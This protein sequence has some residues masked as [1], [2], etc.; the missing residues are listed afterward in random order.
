MT[1]KTMTLKPTRIV[2]HLLL[3]L[4]LLGLTLVWLGQVHAAALPAY[5]C[6]Y[7]SGTN[8]R[9]CE[10]WAKASVGGQELEMPDGTLI[11]FWGYASADLGAPELPGPAI[12]A[13]QGETV[14]VIL[15]NNLAAEPTALHF[16][17]QGLIP[18]QTGAAANGGTTT[19][20]FSASQ[21]GTFLYEAGL[22]PNSQHQ[23]AMGMFGALIVRPTVA[24]SQAYADASTVFQDEALLV[25][26]E[27]DP[28]LNANPTAFDMRKYAPKYWLINGK[29][30][31]QTA[32]IPSAATNS[33][34]L[35]YINA[36]LQ[37][38]TMN[39]L[40]LDQVLLAVDG[41]PLP[42][43]RKVV[44]NTV[45]PGQTVDTLVA[46]PG[47]VPA[48]GAKY[49]LYDGNLLLKNNN[50]AGFGGILTF[51]TLADGTVPGT[52]PVTTAVSLSP[53]PTDG[54]VD[55]V[56]TAT[57][58]SATSAEYFVDAQGAGGSGT[59][60]SSGGGDMWTATLPAA[61]LQGLGF[62]SG[63][64]T[65]YVHGSDGTTWGTFNFAVLHLDKEGPM[66]G[67][68]VLTPNP[69]DGR[70]VVA[71][72]ATGDDSMTGGSDVVAAEYAIDDMMG[73]PTGM[74]VSPVAPVAGLYAT[75]DATTMGGLAEG[76]H[77]LHVRAQDSF[78]NWG[79]HEMA[80]LKVDKTGPAASVGIATPSTLYTRA[81]V[82]V[83]VTLTDV[84]SGS[85]AVNSSIKK[86]EGF[87][88]TLGADGSGFPLTPKDG[89]F[90][91]QTETAYATIPLATI[92]SLT[93]GVHTIHMHGQDSSGNWGAAT[94]ASF[95]ILPE[96]IF[97]DGF[98]SGS[99]SAWSGS[100]GAASVTATAAR[101]GTYGMQVTLA[102]NTPGYAIDN[103]PMAE[104]SY[105]ARFYLNPN[106]TA[107]GNN[108]TPDIFVGFNSANAIVFRVQYNRTNQG[109]YRVRAV[110]T[111]VGGT[112]TTPWVTINNT[113][114]AI[115]IAWQSAN[116]ATFR[117][118][119]G[120]VL[121]QTLTGLNTS[122]YKLETVWLGPSGGLGNS[123]SGTMYFDDF[124]SKRNLYIGP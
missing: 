104:P 35:R 9:T 76:E 123:V 16:Q 115:E 7:D 52:G 15:H 73:T 97:A 67:S 18:D 44:V 89:L 85:P 108:N 14:Q 54:S 80:P 98:E 111:R 110:V 30:Y 83:D 75:I 120:G 28:A 68:I 25:L 99:F 100:S 64:H 23:V 19:Y 36:G 122:A 58:P 43:A 117:L 81:A 27:I 17:G 107:T 48:G 46:M 87:I 12:I 105:H 91:S 96:L 66:S 77:A 22:L 101:T 34:L 88:D 112:T 55:V 10:L 118:Y 45:A 62:A 13:N 93:E 8:T 78:G 74:T 95:T 41:N 109:V 124:G 90:N 86:A 56:L 42:Y 114:N 113:W 39:L 5:T 3:A 47:A 57:I 50:A 26:S 6:T 63:D 72:S 84:P 92:N 79:M 31:P 38:H 119:T 102:G 82:R 60:M 4:A 51:I 21:P 32:E 65:L 70:V 49:A 116:S 33:V 103:S 20:T 29:A 37:P 61:A 2:I 69:S 106:S 94:S 1:M 53:N 11:P 121:R 40:G 71:I 59:A 24:P